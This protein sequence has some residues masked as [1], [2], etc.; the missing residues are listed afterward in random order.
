ML[1]DLATVRMVKL[2][3][4]ELP[5]TTPLL[6]HQRLGLPMG[7]RIQQAQTLGAKKTRRNGRPRLFESLFWIISPYFV[8]KDTL[9]R[10]KLPDCATC[11]SSRYIFRHYTKLQMLG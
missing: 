6:P 9:A 8:V 4:N 5:A 7:G 11:A 2:T 10:H 1:L 3:V